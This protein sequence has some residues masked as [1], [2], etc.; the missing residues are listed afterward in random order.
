MQRE[1]DLFDDESAL[2]RTTPGVSNSVGNLAAHVAGNIR[3]Y[4]GWVLGGVT[5][6]RDRDAE[7]TRRDGSR[8]DLHAELDAAIGAVRQVVPRLDDGR[9]DAPYPDPPDGTSASTRRF[10]MHLCTH[11]SFHLGQAGYL[12][13]LLTGDRR[14][15]DTLTSA[16]LE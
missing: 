4:I 2:W 5:Y 7:F 1:L 6:V 3:H 15:T 8:L 9:L 16:R 11:T 12:R 10:L 13:R 14:S